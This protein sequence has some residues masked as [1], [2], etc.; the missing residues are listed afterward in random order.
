[1]QQRVRRRPGAP[2]A[3]AAR[4]NTP[5]VPPRAPSGRLRPRDSQS[6]DEQAL[7]EIRQLFACYRQVARHDVVNERNEILEARPTTSSRLRR[8]L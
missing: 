3:T 6:D 1:M 2:A 5:P 8:S 4:P 7:E